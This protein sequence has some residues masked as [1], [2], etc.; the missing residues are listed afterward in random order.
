M[1][2]YYL[3]FLGDKEATNQNQFKIQQNDYFNYFEKIIY[4]D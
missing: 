1:S 4:Y 3:T 2:T